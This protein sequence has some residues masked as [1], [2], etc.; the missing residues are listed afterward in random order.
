M[1]QGAVWGRRG[2][3]FACNEAVALDGRTTLAGLLDHPTVVVARNGPHPLVGLQRGGRWTDAQVTLKDG[4]F[5][6][7]VQAGLLLDGH[8]LAVQVLAPLVGA[9]QG[10]GCSR[11]SAWLVFF[12]G[13]QATLA[14]NILA[15]SANLPDVL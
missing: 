5:A 8:R 14:S 6:G 11:W 3:L 7:A 10:A 1:V 4:P 12:V 15:A 9:L 2:Y 13:I